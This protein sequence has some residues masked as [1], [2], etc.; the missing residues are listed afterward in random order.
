MIRT[1]Q[2]HESPLARSIGVLLAERLQKKQTVQPVDFVVTIPKYWLRR[3]L[4]G[5]TGTAPIAEE[6][7]KNLRIPYFPHALHWKRNIRKQSLLSVTERSR[8]VRGALELSRGFDVQDASVLVVDDT[9]TTGA[10]CD[11]AAAVFKRHGAKYV[12]VAVAA[13]A[14]NLDTLDAIDLKSNLNQSAVGAM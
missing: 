10:T 11:E 12:A 13:R 4:K 9:M 8:N 2:F 14:S 5:S 3:V 6:I 7:A 1:K